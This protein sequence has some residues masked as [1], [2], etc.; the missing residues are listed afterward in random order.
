MI[1][2][3]YSGSEHAAFKVFLEFFIGF[4][5]VDFALLVLLRLRSDRLCQLGVFLQGRGALTV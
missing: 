2:H 5:L 1:Q 3:L 4:E